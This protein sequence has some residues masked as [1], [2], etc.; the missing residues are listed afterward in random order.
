MKYFHPKKVFSKV[1][2]FL[3]NVLPYYVIPDRW[4]LK[5]KYKKVFGLKLNLKEPKT[6]NEKIQWLKLYDRN[7][8]YH[9]L[10]DKIAVKDWV[11]NKIGQE[12]II[13]TL[14]IW[15]NV[16]NI[17]FSVLPEQFVIKCNHDAA[18]YSICIDKSSFD[19]KKALE[20]LSRAMSHDYYH[21]EN[22]QWVY[23]NI[24]RKIFAEQFIK[25]T[26]SIKIGLTDYK[27]FCF[28]GEAD[29]VMVAIG[30]ET[31]NTV[32]YF[33]DREWKLLRYNF[34]GINAPQG[35]TI[36]KPERIEEMFTIAEILS[37]GFPFVRVDLYYSEGRIFFGEMTFNPDGGMDS[38]LLPETDLLFG[39]KIKLCD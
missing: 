13:P 6:F 2:Y 18:S 32:F 1:K 19:E 4:Y 23:K 39:S 5:W 20:K 27:F 16:N 35:F 22:K 8:L 34:S 29:C 7:P 11:A 12:Y 28:N 17:D 10:V 15:N 26:K 37:Q 24:Q 3:M 33:F 30:R 25:D 9:T 31:S 14:A 36:P 21:H 38:N